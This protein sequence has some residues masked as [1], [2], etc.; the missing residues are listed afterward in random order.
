[1]PT[2]RW[3]KIE[4]LF[5]AACER[6]AEERRAYL[7]NATDDEALRRE[8]ES[9]LANEDQAAA[10][11]ESNEDEPAA[12]AAEASEARFAAGERIGPYVV[13]EFMKAGGMGEVYKARDTRLDRAVA[14][15]FLP[16]VFAAN[17]AALER[18]QREA[19]AASTLNHPRICTV[20]DMGQHQDRPYFVMELLMGQSLKE[21]IAAG[22]VSTAEIVDFAA[23]IC[24]ALQAAHATGIVHRDIKPA[25]VFLTDRGDIKILD[26]GLAKYG[27]ERA[28][29]PAASEA[30]ET[31]TANTL[32]RPGSVMGTIAYLSPEQARGEEVDSRTDIYSFGVMLYEMA[33]G[34]P[35][36][37]GKTSGELIGS[38]LHQTAVKPSAINPRVGRGL[39][40]IILKAL[41][42]D[43]EARYQSASELLADLQAV[44][45]AGRKRRMRVTAGAV[46][47]TLLAGAIATWV[48]LRISHVRWARNDALPRALLLAESNDVGA[49]LALARQ[50]ER[51]L[52][53]DPEIESLRRIYALPAS[54]HT[55]P[56]GADVYIET[57]SAADASWEFVGKSPITELW[58]SQTETY[59]VRIVKAGF[60][61]V[62]TAVGFAG[63]WERKLT[64]KGAVPPGMVLAPG[65]P[66]DL[67][68]GTLLPD[69]W[70]DK[71]EVTNRQYKEFVTSGGYEN[72]KFW[73]QPFVNGEETL[74]FEQAMAD[75]KDA[76]GRPGPATWQFGTYPEGKD[77]FPV[78]GVSWYEAAAY[79]E[80]AG[81]SLPTVHQWKRAAGVGSP[82]AFM[83]KLS[84][85]GHNGPAKAGSHAGISTVGAYDMA[86]NVREWCWNA[87]GSHRY[88]L[89]GG[90]NDSADMCMN[91]ENRLP[92][93]R[94]DMN[95]FRCVRSLAPIPE[96][97]LA[98]VPLT[99]ENHAGVPP[100][101]EEVFR[102]YRAM[103][104]Y[105]RRP[106]EAAV[107]GVEESPQWR[108]EKITFTAAYGGERVIAYLYL[109]K[110]SKPPFQTVIYAPSLIA[111]YFRGGQY[112]EFPL[113]SFL[114]LSGRAVIYPVYK[115][116]YER[117]TGAYP[118]GKS[119]ERDVIL[120]WGK[121]LGR[122]IDYLETRPDIDVKRL[123]FYGSSLG[124]FWGPIFTQVEPRFKVSVLLSGA[125]DPEIPLPEVDAVH[126]L[127]RNHIPTL[128]IDGRNDYVVP[129]ETHQKPLFRLLG[130]PE[131]DKR[132]VL[133][134]CG[135]ALS[136]FSD[137]IK[138][139]VPWLDRYL[140]PVQ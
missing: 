69:Y 77:E 53:R 82:F 75:F 94:A 10:F 92:F 95:G 2:D 31:V 64:P 21:R 115:G 50:A 112:M 54:I 86:G 100:V 49:A 102:A 6:P 42:K 123:A 120:E 127:P 24:D 126:Y 132:Y 101:S 28:V 97:L 121:D 63:K 103:F 32:T 35:P 45:S 135:H 138:E 12:E 88:I 119:G 137:V 39:E 33:T 113:I 55:S 59:R 65:G 90:W 43:R 133:L 61:P 25:N 8:V 122:S 70:I 48:G 71:F 1:M 110:N 106:L 27:S 98:P 56:P 118:A 129:V 74:S 58:A 111:F 4:S 13:V 76:T 66:T 38:I 19:R 81:K 114:M 107:E 60:E 87:V 36:F 139:V 17:R 68:Q 29:R 52:G 78:N 128:L 93:D 83:A 22:Q 34:R 109:P 67:P 131:R 40:R 99:S 130:T 105:D 7:E 91:P 80:Y 9:L 16:R 89:G 124:A 136:P 11:L 14:L 46:A 125:L 5:H 3:Q 62:E 84:N 72:P 73:K 140:G 134:D 47:G 41:E 26:F 23:Q 44:A 37:D 85:F 51:Y 79:A 96:P 20:H 15:K 18:F 104:S 30:A 117:G 108:K 116:T 57:Y